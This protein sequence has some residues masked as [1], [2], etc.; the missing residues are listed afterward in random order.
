MNKGIRLLGIL[1]A[2]AVM[3]GALAVP[4]AAAESCCEFCEDVAF[5]EYYCEDDCE[6]YCEDGCEC[7]LED[8][9]EAP[10]TFR[11]RVRAFVAY[12]LEGIS[13]SYEVNR[14]ADGSFLDI[15]S[16]WF[17]NSRGFDFDGGALVDLAARFRAIFG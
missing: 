15:F 12:L 17:D 10:E 3:I 7:W 1:L 11:E 4:A 14:K 6:Y 5:C 16:V 9:G 8:E 13:F 2:L